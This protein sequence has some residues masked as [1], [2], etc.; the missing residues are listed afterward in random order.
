MLLKSNIKESLEGRVGIIINELAGK[1]RSEST[2]KMKKYVTNDVD[3]LITRGEREEAWNQGAEEYS[4]L[5]LGGGDGTVYHTVNELLQRGSQL[6]VIA[7][8]PLGTGNALARSVKAKKNFGVLVD[9]LSEDINEIPIKEIPL[10][11]IT[12]W[13]Y[14]GKVKGPLYF[15]FTG[16]GFDAMILNKYKNIEEDGLWAYLRATRQ[17]FSQ[18]MK[19]EV[20]YAQV[21]FW[22]E[23]LY[24]MKDSKEKSRKRQRERKREEKKDEGQ[25]VL[26]ENKEIKGFLDGKYINTAG[27]AT[28]PYYGFGFVAFPYANLAIE[29]NLFHARLVVGEAKS[30]AIELIQ[31]PMAM[32][33]GTYRSDN[34]VDIAASQMSIQFSEGAPFQIA[35]ESMGVVK[36]ITIKFSDECLQLV[37]YSAW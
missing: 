7:L 26:V 10:L 36:E 32:W 34:I 24:L 8:I 5:I 22:G 29:K 3:L 12:A 18:V 31:H 17:A 35:G 30:S 23:G 14:E 16:A 25:F 13:D 1:A 11:E 37:D 19:G 21:N 15:T 6:P 33:Q 2:R 9:L 28:I 4:M 27:A 20:P